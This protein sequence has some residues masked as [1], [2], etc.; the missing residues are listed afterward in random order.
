VWSLGTWELLHVRFTASLHPFFWL[1]KP[2]SNCHTATYGNL[3]II[4]AAIPLGHHL[5]KA[6]IRFCSRLRLFKGS[7][8][9]V[10]AI[11]NCIDYNVQD[12]RLI[13]TNKGHTL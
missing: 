6:N 9:I 7:V 4:S 12:Q 10:S 11:V 8:V 5:K 1:C 2:T 3:L 13:N